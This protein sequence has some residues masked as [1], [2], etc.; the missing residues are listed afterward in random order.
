VA[1]LQGV[2]ALAAGARHS[3]AATPPPGL[4]AAQGN[5]NGVPSRP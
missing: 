5:R 2:V 4:P 3:L 1:G